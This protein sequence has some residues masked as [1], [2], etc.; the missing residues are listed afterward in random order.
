MKCHVKSLLEITRAGDI[1]RSLKKRR[2]RV[3]GSCKVCNRREWLCVEST[4]VLFAHSLGPLTV[5]FRSPLP[6]LWVSTLKSAT[7][8]TLTPRG[9]RP[10]PVARHAPGTDA[11]T[12]KHTQAADLLRINDFIHVQILAV[13]ILMSETHFHGENWVTQNR[14]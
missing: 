5:T 7:W 2:F 10:R 14:S 13:Y 4:G 12:D 8:R 3:L 9:C 6:A 1:G 11:E